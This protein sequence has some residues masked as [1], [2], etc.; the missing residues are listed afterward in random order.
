M[1]LLSRISIFRFIRCTTSAKVCAKEAR[2]T[3]S[4]YYCTYR[5]I[6]G[7]QQLL[8]RSSCSDVSERCSQKFC[9]IHSGKQKKPWHRCKSLRTPL[10]TEYLRWQFQRTFIFFA[11]EILKRTS[12]KALMIIIIFSPSYVSSL[13]DKN[14]TTWQTQSK[15]IKHKL[16]RVKT[17][18]IV[19]TQ[20]A[21][22][23]Y[24]KLN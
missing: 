6:S 16:C 7:I 22:Q 13:F 18:I 24:K 10:F 11:Q 20:Q 12:L 21:K 3:K 8:N 15:N 9:K 5:W 14:K 17:A 23:K 2:K 1:F 4:A 19:I